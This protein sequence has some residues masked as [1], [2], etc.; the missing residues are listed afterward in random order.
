MSVKNK[1]PKLEMEIR[2]KGQE[3]CNLEGRKEGCEEDCGVALGK[4][5]MERNGL[6]YNSRKVKTSTEEEKLA[7]LVHKRFKSRS[8]SHNAC[9]YSVQNCCTPFPTNLFTVYFMTPSIN[10]TI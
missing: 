2:T 7:K 6:S 9:Y 10:L 5:D 4:T 1:N 8:D 3:R